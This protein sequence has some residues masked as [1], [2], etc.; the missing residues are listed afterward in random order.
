M[1][2]A[3]AWTSARATA[4]KPGCETRRGDPHSPQPGVLMQ[5]GAQRLDLSHRPNDDVTHVIKL[6]NWSV[7][8]RPR[9]LSVTAQEGFLDHVRSWFGDTP[10]LCLGEANWWIPTTRSRHPARS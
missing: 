5:R 2:A 3:C 6:R 4:R 8:Y 7:H 1:R 9:T 10:F